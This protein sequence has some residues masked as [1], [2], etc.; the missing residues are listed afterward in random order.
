M[1]LSLIGGYTLIESSQLDWIELPLVITDDSPDQLLNLQPFGEG[2]PRGGV[3]IARSA[4]PIRLP[5]RLLPPNVSLVGAKADETKA[6]ISLNVDLDNDVVVELVAVDEQG[7]SIVTDLGIHARI[8]GSVQIDGDGAARDVIVI[9]DSSAG[10]QVLASGRSDGSGAFDIDFNGYAG[11]VIAIAL[12]KYGVNFEPLKLYNQGDVVHPSTPNGYVFDVT[13]AGTSGATEPE[14]STTGSTQSGSVTFNARPFY[15][16]IASGPLLPEK[17]SDS[18]PPPP[19]I[20]YISDIQSIF[21]G[22]EQVNQFV[23][24]Y[25]VCD[26]GDIILIF[27]RTI[28]TATMPAGWAVTSVPPQ[29]SI[30]DHQAFAIW[31]VA[32]GSEQGQTFVHDFG[33]VVLATMAIIKAPAGYSPAVSEISVG[34]TDIAGAMRTFS[35]T[36][37]SKRSRLLFVAAKRFSGLTGSPNLRYMKLQSPAYPAS[38]PVSFPPDGA[39]LYCGFMV[40]A[41]PD[42]TFT[43]DLEIDYYSS[44]DQVSYVWLEFTTEDL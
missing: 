4:G 37:G 39:A 35:V 15:R 24:E 9:S 18:D 2:I 32:D 1:T 19:H 10:R 42:E 20:A 29:P 17:L 38:Y 12:D 34:L 25:P 11:P 31:K 3:R 28:R 23:R 44:T 36:S 7:V 16:P 8:A 14:W 27:G 40:D 22:A 26:P 33:A 43:L 5:R 13:A 30:G 6:Y 41:E 21:S